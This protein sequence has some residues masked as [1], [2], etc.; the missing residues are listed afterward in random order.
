MI[1]VFCSY[2]GNPAQLVTGEK[3]Y[4]SWPNLKD[5]KYWRC[6]PC[7]A[8]VGC[9]PAN[10]RH[11]MIGIEPM[12]TLANAELR[13]ARMKAHAE[14]DPLWKSKRRTRKQAY[15]WLAD[16]MGIHEKDAHIGLFNIEQC[17]KVVQLC[18][19]L[20]PTNPGN[21]SYTRIGKVKK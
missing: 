15:K 21:Y 4:P 8:Y 16:S 13:S 11:G 2:C 5:S 6:E 17:Q 20:W 14:F 19:G 3:I 7:G 18:K 9:H 1:E 12:G 10:Q